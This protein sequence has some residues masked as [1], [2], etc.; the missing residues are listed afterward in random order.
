M[1]VTREIQTPDTAIGT[2]CSK[3]ADNE[4]MELQVGLEPT[5]CSLQVSRTT[6]VLLKHSVVGMRFE[7]MQA[8]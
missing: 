4:P 1:F 7:L 3:P 6:T 8:D 5:T 2:S